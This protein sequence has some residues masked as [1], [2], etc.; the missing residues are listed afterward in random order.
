M[1]N[2][3]QLRLKS[4]DGKCY[5]TDVCDIEGMF[6][7]IESIPSKKAE[8]IKQWLARLGKESK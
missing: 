7:I 2:C 8:P 4:S 1:T 6:R 3:H 5:N